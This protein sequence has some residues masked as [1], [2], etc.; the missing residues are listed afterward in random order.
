VP[1]FIILEE[2]KNIHLLEKHLISFLGKAAT[3]EFYAVPT[4]PGHPEPNYFPLL[5]FCLS[6]PK[7]W[8]KLVNT[9]KDVS[10]KKIFL[11]GMLLAPNLQGCV[12]ITARK[13]ANDFQEIKISGLFTMPKTGADIKRKEKESNMKLLPPYDLG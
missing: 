13:L 7:N 1:P 2:Q 9:L 12:G 5:N 10:V 8:H 11:T 4:Y 3:G 6:N